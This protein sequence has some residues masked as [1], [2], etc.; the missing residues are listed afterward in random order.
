MKCKTILMH[1][2]G[3]ACAPFARRQI[4]IAA[5]SLRALS[6]MDAKAKG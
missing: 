6:T 5:A 1:C 3:L 2:V 4:A